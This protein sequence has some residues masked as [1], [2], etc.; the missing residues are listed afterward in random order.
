[1]NKAGGLQK[2]LAGKPAPPGA[3]HAVA[4][5]QGARP[6]GKSDPAVPKVKKP[7]SLIRKFAGKVSILSG[8]ITELKCV[9][10]QV[11]NSDL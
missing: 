1:M 10:T 9:S 5:P 7:P 8:K 3:G 6:E 11:C 4:P 2:M